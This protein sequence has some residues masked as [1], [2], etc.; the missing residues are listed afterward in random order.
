MKL[1]NTSHRKVRTLFPPKRE[2]GAMFIPY[3]H[4]S[5]QRHAHVPSPPARAQTARY[6][7]IESEVRE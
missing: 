7:G 6:A 2:K 4:S 5:A 3:P 1:F